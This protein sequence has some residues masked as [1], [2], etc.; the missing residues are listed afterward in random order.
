MIDKNSLVFSTLWLPQTV[1]IF[2]YCLSLD[3]VSL[4]EWN[5]SD[6]FFRLAVAET[7]AESDGISAWLV[8]TSVQPGNPG[9]IWWHI[10]TDPKPCW[11]Y[12]YTTTVIGWQQCRWKAPSPESI[13]QQ[14]IFFFS[15]RDFFIIHISFT[16]FISGKILFGISVISV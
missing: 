14:K 12:T 7:K 11:W 10:F 1:Y 9:V 16:S 2:I 6:N 4:N 13:Y 3:F 5:I 15:S 8:K